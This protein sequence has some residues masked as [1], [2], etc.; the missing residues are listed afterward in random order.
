MTEIKVG[1]LYQYNHPDNTSVYRVVAVTKTHVGFVS[2][3]GPD[4]FVFTQKISAW[5]QYYSQYIPPRKT[6]K[7]WIPIVQ[8]MDQDNIWAYVCGIGSGE[9]KPDCMLPPALKLIDWV[10]F[11]YTESKEKEV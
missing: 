11:E 6:P 8:Y 10:E 9:S 5:K 3:G 7:I 4:E 1:S 2:D